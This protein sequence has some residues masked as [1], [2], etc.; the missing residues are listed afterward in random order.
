MEEK[1]LLDLMTITGRSD[2]TKFRHQVLNP[3]LE[4]GFIEMTIPDKPR[5]SKQRYKITDLGLKMLNQ[6]KEKKSE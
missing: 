1:A 2:R 6:L 4:M 5:S 3:L